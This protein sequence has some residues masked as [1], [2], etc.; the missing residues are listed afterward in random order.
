MGLSLHHIIR[1]LFSRQMIFS[2]FS[3]H[4]TAPTDLPATAAAAAVALLA[5]LLPAE[6][7]AL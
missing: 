4:N 5:L 3:I 2:L 6:D 1:D 7:P